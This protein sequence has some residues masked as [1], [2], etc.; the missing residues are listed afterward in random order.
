MMNSIKYLD[1]NYPPNIHQVKVM[2]PNLLF[3]KIW[4]MHKLKI[5]ISSNINLL[6]MKSHLITLLIIF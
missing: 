6:F 4:K 2:E 1:I 5:C 3:I